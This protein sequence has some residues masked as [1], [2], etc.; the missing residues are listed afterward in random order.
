MLN[1]S[2]GD[3]KNC[4]IPNE[5]RCNSFERR[6]TYKSRTYKVWKD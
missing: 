4:E 6:R 2:Q 3:G 1:S 5:M